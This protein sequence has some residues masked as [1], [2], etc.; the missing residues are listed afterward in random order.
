MRSAVPPVASALL[1]ALWLLTLAACG[2][3]Q[4]YK[5]YP[6][7]ERPP[8]ELATVQFG[9]FGHAKDLL[10][11]GIFVNGSDY[12][13]IRVSPG[14]HRLEY[15]PYAEG[16]QYPVLAMRGAPANAPVLKLEAGLVYVIGAAAGGECQ[17][18]L[19][20]RTPKSGWTVIEWVAP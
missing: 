15:M 17:V 10:I 1:A 16:K 3:Q 18:Y 8:S 2:G 14:L 6:G 11:D 4:I 13:T 12:D 5:L 9:F 20:V 7:P 19:C